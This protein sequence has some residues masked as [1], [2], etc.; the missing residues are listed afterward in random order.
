MCSAA[1]PQSRIEKMFLGS[2]KEPFLVYSFTRLQIQ[3]I[4]LFLGISLTQ[5]NYY[6]EFCQ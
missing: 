3:F 4:F 2:S 1:G 6:D 5:K